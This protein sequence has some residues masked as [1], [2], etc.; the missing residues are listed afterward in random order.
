M[1]TEQLNAI[2]VC[3][4]L[5]PHLPGWV[6]D[7][8][9]RR[10]I[11]ENDGGGKYWAGLE[12]P[13]HPGADITVNTSQKDNRLVISASYPRDWQPYIDGRGR[14][15]RESITVAAT[16]APAQIVKDIQRRIFEATG[17]LA[18]VADCMK[19]KADSEAAQD[20]AVTIARDL[21]GFVGARTT[22]DRGRDYNR[23]K[24]GKETAG[25]CSHLITETNDR[26][27]DSHK[28]G[29]S[30]YSYRIEGEV[31]SG[32]SV[33]LKIDGLNP[34]QAR[35]ILAIWKEHARTAPGDED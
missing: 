33:S 2:E 1:T 28:S 29:A 10:M 9:T 18:Q 3:R 23:A 20:R 11:K 27:F 17:Y 15:Y 16:K 25:G 31:S 5:M 8:N 7:A 22:A 4:S 26:K 13:D 35:A 6:L 21:A 14:V 34:D 30:G 24:T 19:R 12:H 32:G